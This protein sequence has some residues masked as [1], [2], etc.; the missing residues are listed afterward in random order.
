MALIKCPECGREISDQ[1]VSCPHCGFP[2]A[3]IKEEQILVEKEKFQV[4][5]IRSNQRGIHT[6]TF[7]F[8]GLLFGFATIL[9]VMAFVF[10]KIPED[11]GWFI[12]F[13][14]A[15]SLFFAVALA[16]TIQLSIWR[17][18]NEKID[19][20]VIYYYGDTEEFIFYDIH[21]KMYRIKKEVP[22]RLRN[23]MRNY[24]ELLLFYIGKKVNLGFTSTPIDKIENAISKIRSK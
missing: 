3:K 12:G 21:G 11:I 23:N 4:L 18:N 13:V 6:T 9:F 17:K 22:F 5:A 2:L 16:G 14:V 24:G 19:K 15:A 10:F 20:E 8:A 1:A 7:V